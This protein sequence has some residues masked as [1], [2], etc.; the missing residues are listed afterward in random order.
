VEDDDVDTAVLG[1]TVFR[2]VAGDG[3]KL[4]VACGGEIGG[5]D[6]RALEEKTGDGGGSR[7]GQLPVAGELR[8]MNGDVVGVAF[9]AERSG[10]QRRECDR[11]GVRR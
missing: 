2:G 8:R 10:G 9:D 4:G 3:V 6:G 7:S 11:D 1:A 5:V